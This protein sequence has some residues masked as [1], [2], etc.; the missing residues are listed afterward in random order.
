MSNAAANYLHVFSFDTSFVAFE[1]P[2]ASGAR[3]ADT[4]PQEP[5]KP[6]TP[7]AGSWRESIAWWPIEWRKGWA[8]RAEAKQAGGLPWDEAEWQAFLEAVAEINAAVA[9]GE[10]IAF[11]VPA[12]PHDMSTDDEPQG[13]STWHARTRR[14]GMS[15]GSTS[16]SG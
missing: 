11:Q 4:H 8:D 5:T 12:D 9:R 14:P 10:E 15:G 3:T 2:D 1:S 13:A 7:P 16:P 6:A